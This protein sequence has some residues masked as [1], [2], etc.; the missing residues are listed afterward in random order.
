MGSIKKKVF[1]DTS[2]NQS[3]NVKEENTSHSI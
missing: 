3:K 2:N 1:L